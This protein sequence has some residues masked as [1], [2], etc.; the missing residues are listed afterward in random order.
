V[1]DAVSSCALAPP[2]A[3]DST[4]PPPSPTSQLIAEVALQ[5]LSVLPQ[6][7][8]VLFA[9]GMPAAASTSASPGQPSACAWAKPLEPPASRW[10]P[11]D[12]LVWPGV[13]RRQNGAAP[14]EQVGSRFKRGNECMRSNHPRCAQVTIHACSTFI[15]GAGADARADAGADGA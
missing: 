8:E 6:I 2:S 7:D 15:A 14:V 4:S 9:L 3:P 12:K 5:L 13:D 1:L 11:S 10:G